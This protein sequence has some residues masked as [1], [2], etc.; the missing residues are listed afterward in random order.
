MPLDPN[1]RAA[2]RTR[3]AQERAYNE[4]V[5]SGALSDEA[6]A[7]QLQDAEQPGQQG[8]QEEGAEGGRGRRG[9]QT[10]K[11][12]VRSRLAQKLLRGG[13]VAAATRDAN[14]EE[15]ELRREKFGNRW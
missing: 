6:L 7:R 13:A 2:K 8:Q 3:R 14:T 12:G 1:S 15:S 9:R 5:L 11:M 10:K 4:A